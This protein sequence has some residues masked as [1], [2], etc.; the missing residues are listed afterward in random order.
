[1]PNNSKIQSELLSVILAK[2]S[3]LE[4]ASKKGKSKKK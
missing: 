1:M 2:A 3:L 4:K